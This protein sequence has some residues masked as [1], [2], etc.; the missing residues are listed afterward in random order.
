ML[1]DTDGGISILPGTC[2]AVGMWLRLAGG[3]VCDGRLLGWYVALEVSRQPGGLRRVTLSRAKPFAPLF[4]EG[5]WKSTSL[6]GVACALCKLT[7][8]HC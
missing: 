6:G 5:K 3:G 4:G 1:Q 8:C 7:F 2:L